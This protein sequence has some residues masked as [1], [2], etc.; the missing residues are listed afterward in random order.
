MKEIDT[1]I[2]IVGSGLIGLVV[3]HCLS[4]LNY[5]VLIIDKKKLNKKSN[6]NK[7]I[8]TVAVS[9]GSKNFLES[10]SLWSELQLCAEPIKMI[11]VFDRVKSNKIFF[12]NKEINKRL[13]YVI[14]NSKFS[15]KKKGFVKTKPFNFN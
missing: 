12:E 8:R 11:K 7:D 9:E 4:T 15:S 5:R 2:L 13:G 1:D 10:L 14:E 6:K 3:A